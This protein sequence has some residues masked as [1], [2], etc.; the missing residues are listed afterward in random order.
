MDQILTRWQHDFLIKEYPYF[1]K[2][3]F[4]DMKKQWCLAGAVIFSKK[5]WETIQQYLGK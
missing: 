3:E 4:S 2:N 5:D 1:M